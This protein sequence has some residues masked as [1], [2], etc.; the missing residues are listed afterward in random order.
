MS[1]MGKIPDKNASYAYEASMIYLLQYG[2]PNNQR[3]NCIFY[4]TNARTGKLS[5]QDYAKGQVG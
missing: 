3:V 4:E 1:R 2:V 5:S